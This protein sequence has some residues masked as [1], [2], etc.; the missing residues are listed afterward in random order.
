MPKKRTEGT[1]T[2]KTKINRAQLREALTEQML[3]A[4]NR[5]GFVDELFKMLDEIKEPDKKLRCAIELLKFSVPQLASQH[6]KVENEETPVTK[7]VFAPAKLPEP[8]LK[9]VNSD[10]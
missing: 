10:T 4:I 1:S 2:Q 5:R 3:G 9:A 7:I 8:E 6:I